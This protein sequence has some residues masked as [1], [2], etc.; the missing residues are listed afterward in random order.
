MELFYWIGGVS[1]IIILL[2]FPKAILK[3]AFVVGAVVFVIAYLVLH[4]LQGA[5]IL[6]ILSMLGII[7]I[8]LPSSTN[9][10]TVKTKKVYKKPRK[11]W[12]DKQAEKKA[13]KEAY[14]QSLIDEDEELATYEDGY[15]DY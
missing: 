5:I 11:T 14:Y 1:A 3:Y 13:K 2:L 4:T 7:S 9:N 12:R 6:S 10:Q 15:E 8:F